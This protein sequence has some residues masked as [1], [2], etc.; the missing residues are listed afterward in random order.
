VT[1]RFRAPTTGRIRIPLTQVAPVCRNA[2]RLL[3]DAKRGV[4]RFRFDGRVG[5][6]PLRDGTYAAETPS[7]VVRFAIVRG[8]PTRD[9]DK[10]APSVCPPPEPL[11]DG[12]R[13]IV[14][15][16]GPGSSAAPPPLTGSASGG[17][18]DRPGPLPR[19]LGTSLR[20]A[21][22]AAVSLHPAFYLLLALA[23][24]AL[25]AATLPAR[26]VPVAAAGAAIAR[27]R[28]ELTLAGTL[29]LLTVIV[30]YWVMLL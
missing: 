11:S 29:S 17:A 27:R 21:A 24:V 12:R 2:G 9:P 4:N 19:V 3:F 26:A 18:N 6:R 7:G 25:A 8:K 20:E 30:A 13:S 10:L 1:F 28:A 23:I 15:P 5:R 16:P 22:E 14:A